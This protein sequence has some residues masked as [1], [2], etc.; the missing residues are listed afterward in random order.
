MTMWHLLV[1]AFPSDADDSKGGYAKKHGF[2]NELPGPD[3]L[4]SRAAALIQRVRSSLDS[5]SLRFLDEEV[6][7]FSNVTQI[8]ALL[9]LEPDRSKHK[10]LIAELLSAHIVPPRSGESRLYLPV[11]PT[12]K[13]LGIVPESGIPMRSAAKCPFLLTFLTEQLAGGPDE[14]LATGIAPPPQ[15]LASRRVLVTKIASP[16]AP[17]SNPRR[18]SLVWPPLNPSPNKELRSVAVPSSPPV[19]GSSG[20]QQQ[21]KSSVIFKVHD[22]CRQDLLTLQVICIL[23]E[24]FERIGLPLVLVPYAIIPTRTGPELAIGGMIEVISNV[25]SRDQIGKMGGGQTLLEY[26]I[27]EFGQPGSA[28]FKQAQLAFISSLA[29]YAVACHLLAIKVRPGS[30]SAVSPAAASP[31]T[32]HPLHS[33]P[34][35]GSAQRQ[36]YDRFCRPPRPHRLWLYSWHFSR[37]QLGIR[38]GVVQANDGNGR[39]A[40]WHVE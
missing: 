2:C 4:C 35:T 19:A 10:A 30:A 39:V 5:Q 32:C 15:P 40:W 29:A 23:R 3:P 12:S 31:L 7:F 11:A 37:W 14:L 20:A 18:I 34:H 16:T 26:F 1:E 21:R 25:K 22:D 24:E 6:S 38:D 8:S 13:V 17:R 28:T 9:K 27:G 36:H 33:T